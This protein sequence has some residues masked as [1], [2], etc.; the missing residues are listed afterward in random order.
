LRLIEHVPPEEIGEACRAVLHANLS[1]PYPA[2]VQAVAWLLGYQRAG[3]KIQEAIQVVIRDL[4]Q[5]GV[6]REMGGNLT[7]AERGVR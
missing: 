2:L 7:L 5:R 3:K 4:L 1:L 6:L